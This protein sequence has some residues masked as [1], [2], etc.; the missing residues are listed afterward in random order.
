[1]ESNPFLA[2]KVTVSPESRGAR[3]RQCHPDC[4][5][6]S[7]S[8][9]LDATSRLEIRAIGGC[10]IRCLDLFSLHAVLLL[11]IQNCW[12]LLILYTQSVFH[13]HDVNDTDNN[14][15]YDFTAPAF[16]PLGY[17]FEP[18]FGLGLCPSCRECDTTSMSELQVGPKNFQSEGVEIHFF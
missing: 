10:I 9:C 15:L 18:P 11:L 5:R 6:P 1:M 17:Q 7:S 13:I 16:A 3:P 14:S 12:V 4:T 8:S 2:Q